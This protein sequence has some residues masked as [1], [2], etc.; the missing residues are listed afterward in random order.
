M[1][2]Y[3]SWYA[4]V[5]CFVVLV[6]L[7]VLARGRPVGHKFAWIILSI[8]AVLLMAAFFPVVRPSLLGSDYNNRLYTLVAAN[9]F[10]DVILDVYLAITRRWISVIAATTLALAWLWVAAMSSAA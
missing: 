5:A 9:L 2:H 8:S 6:P 7:L 4:L 10:A 1:G 3:S